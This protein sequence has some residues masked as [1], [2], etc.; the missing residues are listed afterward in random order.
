MENRE[1]VDAEKEMLIRRKR[2]GDAEEVIQRKINDE[3]EKKD[4]S[5]VGK[6]ICG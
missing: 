5:D 3:A 2:S 6:G 1:S 4:K